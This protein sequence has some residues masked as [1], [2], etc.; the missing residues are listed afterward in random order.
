MFLRLFL[1]VATGQQIGRI[2]HGFFFL[3]TAFPLSFTEGSV[4]MPLRRGPAEDGHATATPRRVWPQLA[5]PA[6]L[7]QMGG[8][9]L[10]GIR[11]WG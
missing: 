1:H 8:G 4:R 11:A 5:S 2:F 3:L 6:S 7:R 9:G 10:P